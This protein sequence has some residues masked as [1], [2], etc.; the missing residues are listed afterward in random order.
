[1]AE[2]LHAPVKHTWLIIRVKRFLLQAIH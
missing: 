2:I 1:M